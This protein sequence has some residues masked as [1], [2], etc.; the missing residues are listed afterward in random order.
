VDSRKELPFLF[1]ES[2]LC[3]KD[4]DVTRRGYAEFE[5][6]RKTVRFLE[7]ARPTSSPPDR[8]ER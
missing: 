7:S 2:G 4:N 3:S 8:K 6:K 1:C 5:K